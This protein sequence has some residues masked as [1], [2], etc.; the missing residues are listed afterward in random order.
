MIPNFSVGEEKNVQDM[1][2]ILGENVLKSSPVVLRMKPTTVK[3][4]KV[5]KAFVEEIS[6]APNIRNEIAL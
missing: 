2:D 5:I 6:Q 1:M 4:T 3:N